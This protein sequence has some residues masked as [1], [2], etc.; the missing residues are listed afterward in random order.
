M[1]DVLLPS[2]VFMLI[3]L[4]TI[5]ESKASF[6]IGDVEA[7][8]QMVERLLNAQYETDSVNI[9]NCLA[10]IVWVIGYA[11]AMEKK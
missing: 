7:H 10:F 5:T 8:V 9:S 2:F 4:G 3:K 11:T 1:S 6:I